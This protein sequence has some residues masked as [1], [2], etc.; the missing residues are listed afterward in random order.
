M[1]QVEGVAAILIADTKIA[2]FKRNYGKFAGYFEFVGGKIEPQETK[3]EALIRECYEELQVEIII[4]APFKT[5][6]YGYDDFNLV[7][8][9]FVCTTKSMDMILS[10]HDE[11]VWVD[12]TTMDDLNW[13]PAD[14]LIMDDLK[15]LC[16]LL[17]QNG[18]SYA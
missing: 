4:E 10:V 1:K 8:H 17:K 18:G 3:E 2:A 16:V 11:L 12:E 14:R 15:Q 13:L 6:H 9:T 5:I 7:L